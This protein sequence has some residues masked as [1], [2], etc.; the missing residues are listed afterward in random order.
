MQ[1]G[2]IGRIQI[3]GTLAGIV[4]AVIFALCGFGYWALVLR[5]ITSS[6]CVAFGAWLACGW[7]PRFPVFD[8]EVKSLVRFGMHVVGYSVTVTLAKSADRMLLGLVYRPDQV[9][10]YQNAMNM[11]ENSIQMALVQMH[12]VGSTALGKLQSNPTALREKYETALSMVAY[13][14]MPLAAI[15]SVTGEDLTVIL[16]GGRWRAAGTL[17]SIIALKGIFHVVESSS[18]WL[19]LSIGRADRWQ[20]WGIVTT[21]ILVAAVLAGLPFGPNGVA[22][23]VVAACMVNALPAVAYAGRPIG[24]GAAVVIRAVHRQLI[25]AISTV[26]AGWWLQSTVLNDYSSFARIILLGLFCICV[27]LAVVVGLFRFGEPIR[28]AR[29]IVQDLLGRR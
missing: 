26:A 6:F 2:R 16:L 8:K 5:P 12:R 3:L 20:R 29:S 1:F 13:F 22:M 7:R 19:H 15:L 17:L 11:Y 10:Y 24:L 27:Y 9:G 25:G 4:V 28:L 21:V 23:G 18:G 14:V